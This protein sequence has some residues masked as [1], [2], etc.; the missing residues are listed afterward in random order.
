[1]LNAAKKA[2]AKKAT[3][4]QLGL[5]LHEGVPF[6]PRPYGIGSPQMNGAASRV[7]VADHNCVMCQ[8]IVQRVRAEMIMNNLGTKVLGP[9]TQYQRMEDNWAKSAVISPPFPSESGSVQ[10]FLEV[11]S[12][13]ASK[14]KQPPKPDQHQS[15][16][17]V[18]VEADARVSVKDQ[19]RAQ[20]M[21]A[22]RAQA[23]RAA[24]RRSS[25]S[26]TENPGA[27]VEP[28]TAEQ[29][30]AYGRSHPIFQIR[31]PAVPSYVPHELPPPD[32]RT[33]KAWKTKR[34]RFDDFWEWRPTATRYAD[35][36]SLP[37]KA[38]ERAQ[39][40]FEEQEMFKTVYTV[41]EEICTKR[42][43]LAFYHVCGHLMRKY[44]DIARGLIWQD[45]HDAICMHL[46]FCNINSYIQNGPHSQHNIA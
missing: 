11:A 31:P 41:V 46:D 29:M 28:L 18:L 34:E 3:A 16:L 13:I 26:G 24:A 8:Y 45:R 22:Q 12:H 19:I 20:R 9:P 21:E 4:A 2:G 36:Y 35:L 27:R 10:A 15:D 7:S 40:R 42:M 14:F 32:V 23:R 6:Q 1:V 5:N 44:R 17:P 25:R 37:L 39:Q 38:E 43:P 30:A 33:H